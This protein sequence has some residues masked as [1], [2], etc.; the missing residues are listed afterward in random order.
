MF[1]SPTSNPPALLSVN[2]IPILI[3]WC[4][5]SLG[6]PPFKFR[7]MA[8][9]GTGGEFEVEEGVEKAAVTQHP[10]GILGCGF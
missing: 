10:F 3:D 7:R 2:G 4:F 6:F 1:L 5:F 8:S 9:G